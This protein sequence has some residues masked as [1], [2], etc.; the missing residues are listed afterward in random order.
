MT[1]P[2][3]LNPAL[4]GD[5]DGDYRFIGNFRRQWSS[6]TVPYETFGIGSD[7]RNPFHKNNTGLGTAL[8]YDK[9]GDSKLKTLQFNIAGSIAVDLDH[10][11]K[12]VIR[13]GFQTGVTQKSIDYSALRFDNQY[14][15]VYDP[16]TPSNENFGTST[17]TY[18]NFNAGITYSKIL[19]KT[20]NVKFGFGLFNINEPNQSY[21][22]NTNIIL[23]RRY[24][25]HA[26]GE[27]DINPNADLLPAVL[28]MQQAK[29]NEI[30]IGTAYRYKID[31]RRKHYRALYAG[32]YTRAKD[33]G[34]ITL[35]MDYNNFYVSASYD[36]N[37]SKLAKAS[38]S[39][40]G[41]E[42]SVIYI[43]KKYPKRK[44]FNQCPDWM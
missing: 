21:F 34:F 6:V 44:T 37:Y 15:D 20:K 30:I 42:L 22:G 18:L 39:R 25:F 4:T 24:T 1:S 32:L 27:F 43:I 28:V 36:I 11:S 7:A 5:F 26:S 35:G 41:F 10:R 14:K 8:F 9:T 3:N 2:M 40:G 23:D 16:N 31:K 38:H 17:K 13:M 12:N 19:S 33:A 29:Y